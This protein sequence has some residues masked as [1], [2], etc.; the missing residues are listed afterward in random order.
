[1][2]VLEMTFQ[3]SLPVPLPLSTKEPDPACTCIEMPTVTLEGA[4]L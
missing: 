4:A 3:I 2:E 1:M